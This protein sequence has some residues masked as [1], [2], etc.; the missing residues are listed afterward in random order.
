MLLETGAND[1]L[2]APWQSRE[3]AA[4][5][6]TATGSHRPVL[7][8]TRLNAG[9]ATSSFGQAAGNTTMLLTFLAHELG[10]KQ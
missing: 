3:F 5:L 4:A 9:H 6:Q 10:L 7:L 1:P 8:V 2:V